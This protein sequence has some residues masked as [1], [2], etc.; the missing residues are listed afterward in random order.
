MKLAVALFSWLKARAE[1]GERMLSNIELAEEL[2]C[3]PG[4]IA[5]ALER[6]QLTR[7]IKVYRTGVAGNMQRKVHIVATGHC[8][9]WSMRAPEPVI[10]EDDDGRYRAAPAFAGCPHAELGRRLGARRYGPVTPGARSSLR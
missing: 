4:A 5:H 10:I 3:S 9:A 6:I 8:T 1:A 7:R 2:G